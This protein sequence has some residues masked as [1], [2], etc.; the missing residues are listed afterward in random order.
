VKVLILGSD[1]RGKDFLKGTE[2]ERLADP[3]LLEE[4]KQY[5]VILCEQLLQMVTRAEVVP[6]LEKL[7][8]YLV[9]DGEL[10]V[11]TPALEL[12]ARQII[13]QPDPQPE[14]YIAIYGP[15]AL[16]YKSGFT[17]LW[18]RMAMEHVGYLIKR[19]SQEIVQYER[20]GQKRQTL[21]NLVIGIK[22]ASD[23][24]TAID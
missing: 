15:D 17:L 8:N 5:D 18:L 20:D 13:Q 9:P 16:Q 2:V 11:S 23:P 3:A 21:Q 19:A 6:Y 12:A 14:T 24:A 22:H 10:W 7:K 1:Q 4:G